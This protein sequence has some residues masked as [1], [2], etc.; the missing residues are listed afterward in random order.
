MKKLNMFNFLHLK[1]LKLSD[2][3]VLSWRQREICTLIFCVNIRFCKSRSYLQQNLKIVFD[4]W[5]KYKFI[6]R[7]RYLTTWLLK[8]KK[9][10]SHKVF[11][12]L[13]VA[14]LE[15]SELSKMELFVKIVDYIKPLTVFTK[16]SILDVWLGCKYTFA[17]WKYLKTNDFAFSLNTQL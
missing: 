13:S 8:L 17:L 10:N 6:N 3:I 1:I 11:S 9:L 7:K 14:F 4:Y 2:T 12:Q 5:K 15:P 16:G